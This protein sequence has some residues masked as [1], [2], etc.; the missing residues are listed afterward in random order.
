MIYAEI[1]SKKIYQNLKFSELPFLKDINNLPKWTFNINWNT[2]FYINKIENDIDYRK[3]ILNGTML[4]KIVKLSINFHG[5]LICI[6]KQENFYYIIILA[7]KY[8]SENIGAG[9]LNK[10]LR[11]CDLNL[12]YINNYC[13]D[14]L[15]A[16]KPIKKYLKERNIIQNILKNTNGILKICMD[17]PNSSSEY[18]TIKGNEIV[19]HFDKNNIH[20][21]VKD[22]FL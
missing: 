7:S 17:F 12:A 10:N 2:E 3:G 13:N 15:S 14:N 4:N 20:E 6:I 8:Y 22:N 5:D 16:H 18:V 9:Q 1:F 19:L 11:S 21:F